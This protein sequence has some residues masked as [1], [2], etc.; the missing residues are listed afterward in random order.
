MIIVP[1]HAHNNDNLN[2]TASV[3]E[4]GNEQLDCRI[5]HGWIVC[6]LTCKHF[7][8][9]YKMLKNV[10]LGT[11]QYARHKKISSH[12]PS[13]RT[14]C[15][16]CVT[17]RVPTVPTSSV[18]PSRIRLPR[19]SCPP[20]PRPSN[21]CRWN[22]HYLLHPHHHHDGCWLPD[23]HEWNSATPDNKQELSKQCDGWPSKYLLGND[24]LRRSGKACCKNDHLW[25]SKLVW[26]NL[27]KTIRVQNIKHCVCRPL[28]RSSVAGTETA[29]HCSQ[30]V[31]C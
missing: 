29:A 31:S 21:S 18:M 1:H 20:S 12:K 30:Q 24:H 11:H 22:R 13:S 8:V 19:P 15:S 14:E 27:G 10:S 9:A 25:L 6:Q 23:R 3:S 28:T 5:S 16:I 17:E 4:Y 26:E 2:C 7:C